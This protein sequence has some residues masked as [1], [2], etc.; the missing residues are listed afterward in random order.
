[1]TIEQSVKL[2]RENYPNDQLWFLTKEGATNDKAHPLPVNYWVIGAIDSLGPVIGQNF[3]MSRFANST[4]PEGKWGFIT[5]TTVEKVEITEGGFTFTTKNS[6]YK[7]V[8]I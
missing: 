1:M 3:L 5:T 4:N 2:V 8:K 6:V 7:V